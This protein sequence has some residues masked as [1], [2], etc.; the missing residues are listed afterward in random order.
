V[1]ERR[2]KTLQAMTSTPKFARQ[3]PVAHSQ[4][5]L[6]CL[7]YA[8]GSAAVFSGWGERLKPEIEVWTAQ[9]RGRGMRFRERPFESVA[10]MV[11]EYYE[12]LRPTVESGL[13][14]PFAFYGHSLGGLMAWE[15]TRRLEAD[16]LPLPEHLFIGATVP[17]HMGLIHAR[18]SHLP[19][20]G[21]VEAIQERYGGIPPQV[22][23]EREL[24]DIF[25]PPLK[26]DFAAYEGYKY[27]AARVSVP[28]TAFAGTDDPGLPAP[29][30]EEWE[31]H[32]SGRFELRIVP[33][34]HFFL[35]ES[36]EAVLRLIRQALDEGPRA[37][38]GAVDADS[39][40]E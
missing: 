26:A 33:G 24:M 22:L 17:P 8:G 35:T 28:L 30:M 38:V 14:V 18:I 2:R 29:L 4:W 6:Y 1:P 15:L 10:E 9:P 32:T 36:S 39:L 19:D 21:F 37:V 3:T 40:R 13:T 25:L 27:R 31:R 23:A 12:A 11:E 16:G 20:E 7:P 34:E 5:R